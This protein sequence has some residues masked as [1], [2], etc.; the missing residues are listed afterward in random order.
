MTVLYQIVLEVMYGPTWVP[1]RD[2]S[3]IDL[4]LKWG[5]FLRLCH[6]RRKN[7]EALLKNA[8]KPERLFECKRNTI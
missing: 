4:L 6:F 5:A 3:V 8:A 7:L 2:I 1:K